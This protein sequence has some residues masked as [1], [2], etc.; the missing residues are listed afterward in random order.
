MLMR[1]DGTM[2]PP[3]CMKL[4]GATER[5][6]KTL[7][8]PV[9]PPCGD[10]GPGLAELGGDWTMPPKSRCEESLAPGLAQHGPACSSGG[11][12]RGGGGRVEGR[13]CGVQLSHALQ[14]RRTRP[15]P[16]VPG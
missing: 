2:E 5:T 1:V 12:K 3:V 14:G 10:F 13:S 15:L 6:V 7:Y 4:V 9:K 16:V 11:R 8:L